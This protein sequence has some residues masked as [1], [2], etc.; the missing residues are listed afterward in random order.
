M[1]KQFADFLKQCKQI[2]DSFFC[3]A[4][5]FLMEQLTDYLNLDSSKSYSFEYLIGQARKTQHKET[6]PLFWQALLALHKSVPA[7]KGTKP[8]AWL[9][10]VNIIERLQGYSGAQLFA[11]KN[12]KHK[13][14]QRLYFAYML[15][16]EH[17][18]YM[19][20]KDDGYSPSAEILVVYSQAHL[21]DD[22]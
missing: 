4:E 13:R 15:S 22:H 14:I 1:S 19:A 17:L 18:R 20:G 9:K 6:H 12:I 2:N 16:W 3:Y 7:N 5:Y 21:H 8:V 10:F 11:D